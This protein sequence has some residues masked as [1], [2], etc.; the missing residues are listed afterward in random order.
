MG[1]DTPPKKKLK[2]KKKVKPV[3]PKTLTANI[4]EL[5]RNEMKEEP[6]EEFVN[7]APKKAA[8]PPPPKTSDSSSSESANF[9]T[10][11]T[12]GVQA[13]PTGSKESSIPKRP[14]KV[15]HGS[16]EDKVIEY[17]I[18]IGRTYS[19]SS[20]TLS[21]DSCFVPDQAKFNTYRALGSTQKHPNQNAQQSKKVEV[22]GKFADAIP[23]DPATFSG[24]VKG[25]T[26][27][28]GAGPTPEYLCGRREI[29]L[30]KESINAAIDE[31]LNT[32]R[33]DLDLIVRV[34]R[35]GPFPIVSLTVTTNP[36]CNIATSI[37]S[38]GGESMTSS[39][40]QSVVDDCR[41]D[42]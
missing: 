15:V 38:D 11:K 7:T 25:E 8:P 3:I 19:Q 29:Q 16:K 21:Y 20:G 18:D 2:K 22:V 9:E 30:A 34:Q 37:A 10:I 17:K 42:L 27:P 6:P 1:N 23:F 31:Y 32:D 24:L 4:G 13:S 28:P 41:L 40:A 35:R 33:D 12:S 14:T 36:R 5:R 26:C 39:A